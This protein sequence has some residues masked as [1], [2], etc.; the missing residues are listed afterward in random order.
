MGVPLDGTVDCRYPIWLIA[1]GW[2]LYFLALLVAII[3]I[4]RV[5]IHETEYELIKKLA[6]SMKPDRNWGP[7]DPLLHFHWKRAIEQQSG[8]VPYTLN[9]ISRRVK[10]E[11]LT[12][13]ISN[14]EENVI[15][16]SRRPSITMVR[17]PNYARHYDEPGVMV[18]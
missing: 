15:P 4:I 9:T 14:S 10:E 13:V 12:T 7:V 3:F 6:N 16:K 8:P 2:S 1:T 11:D 5:V 18:D 17:M